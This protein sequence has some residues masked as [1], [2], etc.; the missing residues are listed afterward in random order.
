MVIPGFPFRRG[1]W[2]LKIPTDVEVEVN[3]RLPV[4][5]SLSVTSSQPTS[6]TLIADSHNNIEVHAENTRFRRGPSRRA[7]KHQDP[8]VALFIQY[9]RG[10]IESSKCLKERGQI[11]A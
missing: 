3:S 6:L 2:N 1:W 4:E 9:E 5:D 7:K 8:R 11:H 10:I